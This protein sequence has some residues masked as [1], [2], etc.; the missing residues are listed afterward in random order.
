[1]TINIFLA[2][3]T[4]LIPNIVITQ[5]LF[6]VVECCF[7]GGIP[8]SESLKMSHYEFHIDS[9]LMGILRVMHNA[10]E[11]SC[12]TTPQIAINLQLCVYILDIKSSFSSIPFILY[13]KWSN[14]GL[15]FPR[16]IEMINSWNTVF[17][18][19]SD[20]C[21]FSWNLHWPRSKNPLFWSIFHLI[22]M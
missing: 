6:F 5:F 4:S 21:E 16:K 19:N 10:V 11:F 8:L 12:V 22:L 18:A 17:K 13:L 1:M 14:P 9:S 3:S 20:V 7:Q 2:H 15:K